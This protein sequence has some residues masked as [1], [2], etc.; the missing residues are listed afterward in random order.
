MHRR[1]KSATLE[2]T[3]VHAPRIITPK[4]R[5]LVWQHTLKHPV[6]VTRISRPTH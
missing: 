4:Q 5:P 6:F 2:V 1:I 3:A